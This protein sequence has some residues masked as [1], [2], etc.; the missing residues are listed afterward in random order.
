MLTLKIITQEKKLLEEEVESVTAPAFDGEITILP[1]HIPLF[2]KIN[3]G[4][5][6]YRVKGQEHSIVIADGFMDVGPNSTVTLMVDTAVRS[7]DIDVLKA[8]EAKRKAE[9]LMSQKLDERD[10]MLAEASLRKALMEIQ[11]FNK[12]KKV[13]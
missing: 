9:E 4:E 7:D 8:E 10:F 2:T 3:T 12:R 5:L 6:V 1:S 13:S 11:T